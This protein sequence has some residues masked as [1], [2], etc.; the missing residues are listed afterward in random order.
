VRR[1]VLLDKEVEIGVLGKKDVC[2]LVLSDGEEVVVGRH[3][4]GD[5]P[6]ALL[7][8]S[9]QISVSTPPRSQVLHPNVVI[10]SKITSTF[11]RSRGQLGCHQDCC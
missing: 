10:A 9:K 4:L 8:T 3:L 1:N 2:V 5:N 6:A 7:A 11:I